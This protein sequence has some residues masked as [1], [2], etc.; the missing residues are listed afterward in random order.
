[1]L[2]ANGKRTNSAI[3]MSGAAPVITAALLAMAGGFSPGKCAL[4]SLGD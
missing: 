1:M 3:A 4:H 2:A